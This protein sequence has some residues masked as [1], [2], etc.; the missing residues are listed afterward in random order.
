MISFLLSSL[1]DHTII[2]AFLFILYGAY[3]LLTTPRPHYPPGPK[4]APVIG[5]ILQISPEHPELLF[6]RWA[7]KFGD[8]VYLHILGH[9][10]IVLSNLDVVR[11]LLDKRSS[12]YSDRPRFVLFSELMGWKSASTHVRYGPRFRKHRRFIQQTF[13]QRASA[14]FHPLQEQETIVLLDGL[15]QSPAAFV[16][17]F[18]RFAAATILPITYGHKITSVDDL[19]VR[20]AERAGTLTVE[21]G[22]PAATLV[23]FIPIL[24]HVPTWAPFSG[25]KRRA[26]VARAAVDDMMNVPFD[27]VKREMRAGTAT[28]S[29]TSILLEAHCSTK[30]KADS[31]T[32]IEDEEDIK[33]AAGTLFAD[34]TLAVME[35]FILAMVRNPE[36]FRKAQD[37]IDR[38]VGADRLPTMDD[39]G[40]LPY[41][42]CVLKE[43]LRWNPPVPL[44]M[45]HRLMEDDIYNGYHIPKGATV[46]AN[47]YAMLQQCSEAGSFRPERYLNNDENLAD[48]RE[49]VFGFGRRI[50]PGRHFAEASIWSMTSSIIATFDISKSVERQGGEVTPPFDV[51]SGFIRHPKPF[52][53]SICPRSEKAA[54]LIQHA[55][56][57]TE[58]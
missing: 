37:E 3:R 5:N 46:V 47:I 49:L 12:I 30:D 54:S 6:Q 39:R 56:A 44:G 24:K 55:K 21:S 10:M 29:F 4:P 48:P 26:L 42:E 17:H 31:A 41:L 35:T 33:G 40:S 52:S 50:C 51:T 32:A 1:A 38:V 20:L 23:D 13:N 2:F 58:L 25:F 43:V 15:L 34:T 19:F 57:Y 14:T 36:V 28:P 11:D 45:P 53:C 16:Q 7:S 22:T 8:L 18:R 27:M 9:P